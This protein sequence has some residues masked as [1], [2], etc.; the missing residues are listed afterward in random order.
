MTRPIITRPT[1]ADRDLIRQ[2]LEE[3]LRDT[4]RREGIDRSHADDLIK[5]I[6]AQAALIERDL[7]SNGTEVHFLVARTEQTIVGTAAF[8][9]ANRIIR[10]HLDID[11]NLVPEV[12]AVYIRPSH[13]GHGVGTRLFREILTRLHQR[14]TEQ[15]VLDSGY[16]AAQAFWHQRLGEPTV[17]VRDYWEPGADHHVWH[18]AIAD[19]L[20]EEK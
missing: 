2:L 19:Y 1:P 18:R 17:R 8:G 4:F 6:D 12:K 5:E 16:R 14:A 11:H 3:T 10:A 7:N 15:F 9:P 13:Q 20:A